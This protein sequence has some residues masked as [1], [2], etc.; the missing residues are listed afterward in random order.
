MLLTKRRLICGIPVNEITSAKIEDKPAP[1]LVFY[2]GWT[3]NK[4]NASNFAS[5]L[6]KSGFRLIF[7]DA[8]YHGERS[9]TKLFMWDA[10]YI[11]SSVLETA[12]E[13]PC[14]IDYYHQKNLIKADFISVA[15]IS[16]GGL[17]TNVILRKYPEVKAA[18]SLMG[19]PCLS[20]YAE[21]ISLEGVWNLMEEIEN[22]Y[23]NLTTPDERIA[24]GIYNKEVD[25]I[26]DMIPQLADWDLSK[27]PEKLAGKPVFYWHAK[28]DPLVPYRLTAEFFDQVKDLSEAKNIYL[29]ADPTGTH[30]V[31]LIEF[32]RLTEFLQLSY[33]M[34][35]NS[36]RKTNLSEL[37]AL[38]NQNIENAK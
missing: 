27:K 25:L 3:S 22:F 19:T 6:V 20:K 35:G 17:I 31:P 4:E 33:R 36:N 18:G 15:G 2:H 13:F 10:H 30:T 11:F 12:K 16:M 23:P 37:W 14:I 24:Q 26:T 7:P 38:T 1:L 29:K 34:I 5:V 21:W 8:A 32:K 9:K 28:P